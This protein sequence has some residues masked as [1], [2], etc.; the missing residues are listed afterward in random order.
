M[1]EYLKR[2]KNL[3]DDRSAKKVLKQQIQDD[4]NGHYN[5]VPQ[6]NTIIHESDVSTE[7]PDQRIKNKMKDKY[8]YKENQKMFK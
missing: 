6:A 7:D 8:N 3:P 5:W 1:F 4:Q 2:P